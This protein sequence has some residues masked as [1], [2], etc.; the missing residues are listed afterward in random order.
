M[1]QPSARLVGGRTPEQQSPAD[2]RLPLATRCWRGF[3][4]TLVIGPVLIPLAWLLRRAVIDD[5]ARYRAWAQSQ[6][7]LSLEFGHVRFPSPSTIAGDQLTVRTDVPTRYLGTFHQWRCRRK[8]E[9]IKIDC[10]EATLNLR[11]LP[12]WSQWLCDELLLTDDPF[13]S[14]H[15]IQC[16][17]DRLRLL[18][19]DG[20]ETLFQ[21]RILIDPA[22]PEHTAWLT[23]MTDEQGGQKA[24]AIECSV[25]DGQLQ[26]DIRAG[27]CP[28]PC[29][30][31]KTGRSWE[32][33]LL[34][35]SV[36]RGDAWIDRS[37]T[38]SQTEFVAEIE[39]IDLQSLGE[40]LWS[41][42]EARLTGH[43]KAYLVQANY[44]NGQLRGFD[45]ILTSRHGTATGAALAAAADMLRLQ[46]AD[47]VTNKTQ[48]KSHDFPFDDLRLR[49]TLADGQ[50]T[51]RAMA[52]TYGN[53]VSYAEEPLL[54]L[55]AGRVQ[56]AAPR[57]SWRC[58]R[59][60]VD[61]RT[62]VR[63]AGELVRALVVRL[64]S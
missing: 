10:E 38:T 34:E 15:R 53:I 61:G 21:A 42:P 44:V 24:V 31:L 62:M 40:L 47:S 59:A 18:D 27:A 39:P 17:A 9:Q 50:L 46:L 30:F 13:F 1:V 16:R 5:A 54:R 23:A 49:L 6:W 55:D 8:D 58:S 45:L 35:S 28:L 64:E 51:A 26:V 4:L 36:W 48:W 7:Q 22:D 33:L 29:S 20:T 11:E 3:M 56:M 37:P 25:Q 14:S 32:S 41:T 2:A 52:E 12:R 43:A 60:T 57:K 19:S 63:F